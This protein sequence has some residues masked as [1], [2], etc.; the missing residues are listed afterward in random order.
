MSPRDK[1]V[2]IFRYDK[3]KKY[4]LIS[5]HLENKPGALGNLANLL[6][7][8]DINI[9]EGFFGGMSYEANATVSFFVESTNKRV[10]KGW[11]KDFLESSVY[12]SD[13]EVKE[14]IDGLLTDSLNFPL[15]WNTGDRAILMRVEGVRAML[16][17][18]KSAS[19]DGDATIYSQGFSY[20]KA[21]WDNL[22]A[23]YHPPS[24]EALAEFLG[25][26]SATG[27]GRP[28]L[29]ELDQ[30]KRRAKL[31]FYDNFECAGQNTGGLTSSF[32]RGHIS[33]A[34]SAYFGG[35]V[36]AVEKK[37]ASKGDDCCE[38]EIAP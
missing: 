3:S 14:S 1:D 7:I 15:T 35:Y 13:V 32:V 18:M 6:A 2:V 22:F 16:E 29:V 30:A 9:L 11:I 4:F 34:F 20:G 38:F 27:W 19:S 28:E 37:C 17:S 25:I 12:V 24:K 21:A 33:G 31:K 26:Y 36:R 8:R 10:D 5:L 23:T